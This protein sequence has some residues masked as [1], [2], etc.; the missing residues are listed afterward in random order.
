MKHCFA[1]DY[2]YNEVSF[3]NFYKSSLEKFE[4]VSEMS[5]ILKQI[6]NNTRINK[7]PNDSTIFRYTLFIVIHGQF[8][9]Q[10]KFMYVY[11]SRR[12]HQ[13]EYQKN[14]IFFS[15]LNI[16]FNIKKQSN[17]TSQSSDPLLNFFPLEKLIDSI[18]KFH[19]RKLKIGF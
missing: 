11:K 3:A 13:F 9:M 19:I 16:S 6:L 2:L 17:I 14:T 1:I 15:F 18:A 8:I 7:Q 10:S 5:L 4:K 12:T